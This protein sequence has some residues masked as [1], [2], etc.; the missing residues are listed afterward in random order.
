M[1]VFVNELAPPHARSRQG[2][3]V[4]QC[5][6]IMKATLVTSN[7]KLPCFVCYLKIINTLKNNVRI[8]K[9]LSKELNNGITILIG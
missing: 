3:C 9:Q 4:R 7:L 5:R 6:R 2:Q 8:L 1:S